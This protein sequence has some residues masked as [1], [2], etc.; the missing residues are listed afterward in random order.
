[1]RLLLVESGESPS[2]EPRTATA[3]P[4][5]TSAAA[6]SVRRL[7]RRGRGITVVGTPQQGVLVTR[8]KERL[9]LAREQGYRRSELIELLESLH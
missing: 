7:R 2:L 3:P 9:Q 4:V 1:V 5:R 8:A 6:A